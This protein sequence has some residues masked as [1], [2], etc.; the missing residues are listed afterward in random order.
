MHFVLNLS[1]R[2]LPRSAYLDHRHS[3][4]NG[5]VEV[6]GKREGGIAQTC[7]RVYWGSPSLPSGIRGGR[8]NLPHRRIHGIRLSLS[9]AL[10]ITIAVDYFQLL[11]VLVLQERLFPQRLVVF[12]A[13]KHLFGLL[14]GNVDDGGWGL[15]VSVSIAVAAFAAVGGT[16][17]ARD[18]G[19][20]RVLCLGDGILDEARCGGFVDCELACVRS[21][22]EWTGIRTRRRVCERIR[23]FGRI[24]CILDFIEIL[25]YSVLWDD[26]F[27]VVRTTK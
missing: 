20:C 9:L 21:S 25:S 17:G 22:V 11:V 23:T 13:L 3:L 24:L 15:A 8:R 5:K 14:C 7:K 1:R 27:A 10:L 16:G 6:D 26:I 4:R 2:T 18:G 12:L 19:R